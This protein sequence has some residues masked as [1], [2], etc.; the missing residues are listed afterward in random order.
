MIQ[1]HPHSA[2]E[3]SNYSESGSDYKGIRETTT[4]TRV[5]K[6][7]IAKKL[8]KSTNK[9]DKRLLRLH[10]IV[11]DKANPTNLKA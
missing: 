9:V 3:S 11:D 2:E 10:K 7:K 8:I 6:D 5:Y 1:D 4:K